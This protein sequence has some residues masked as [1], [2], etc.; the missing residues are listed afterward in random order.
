MAKKRMLEVFDLLLKDLMDTNALF[1]RKVV[2]LG[3]DFRQTLHVVRYRKKEDFIN[4]SLLYSSIWNELEKLKLSENMRAKTDPAFCDYLL[5]IE[6]RQERV[7]SAN[8][9]EIPY[10]LIIPY[11][12]EKQSLDKLFI[13]IDSN[14]D[15][16]CSNSSCTYSC[17]ILTTKNDFVDKINGMLIDRFTRKLKIF[18][19]SDEAIEFNNQT[20]FEDLLHTLNPPGLPPYKLSLK[21]NCPIILLRNLNPCEGLYNGTRLT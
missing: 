10:S 3:D 2:V 1:G 5:R 4:K 21:E 11:T 16:L 19:R 20:Q 13:A 12:T 14:L 7:N 17:V 15:S 8:K 6:N 18:I 9:I